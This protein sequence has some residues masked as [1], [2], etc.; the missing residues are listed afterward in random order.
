MLL[1]LQYFEN[2]IPW[3]QFGSILQQNE[4]MT[5]FANAAA[6]TN[7]PAKPLKHRNNNKHPRNKPN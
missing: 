3:D 4:P 2:N 1:E 7:Q 5:I 6:D